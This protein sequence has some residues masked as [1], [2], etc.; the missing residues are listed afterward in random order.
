MAVTDG[1][2]GVNI[3]TGGGL[4]QGPKGLELDPQQLGDKNH[5]PISLIKDLDAAATAADITSAFNV[6]LRE[7]RRTKRM[8]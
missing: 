2:L 3:A 4:R 8:R 1:R 6:L 7:L 5:E